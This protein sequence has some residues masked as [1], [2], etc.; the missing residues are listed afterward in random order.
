[1]IE[2]SLKLYVAKDIDAYVSTEIFAKET[3]VFDK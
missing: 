2:M 1:M 3:L